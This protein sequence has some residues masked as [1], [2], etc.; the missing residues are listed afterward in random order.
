MPTLM[1]R[2]EKRANLFEQLKDINDRTQYDPQGQDLEQLNRLDAELDREDAIIA[3]IEGEQA[4]EQVYNRV[5]RTGVV[6]A[7][8][9]GQG[10]GE[11]AEYREAWSAF[12]RDGTQDMDP[13]MR[14]VLNAG[15]VN[16]PKNAAGVGT[17]SAGGYA[18]PPEFREKFVQTLKY[19]GPMLSE[20]EII[21][22]ESGANMPWPTNDDTGNVGAILAEN[23][24]V[25]EQDVTL[26]QASIDAYM[27]TSK[28]VRVSFQLMQDMPTFDSW[29]IERLGE[30]I[31]RI[32]NAHFTTGTNSSQPN[33]I[34]TGG[35]VGVT[36]TGSFAT[37]GVLGTGK[38]DNIIDLVE[39][40]D[41]AYGAST[42]LKFMG[43]QAVR[44]AVRKLQDSQG[45][46]MWEISL[47]N[48][49]PDSLLGYQFL[50]NNDMAT[51]AVSSKSLLF[52]DIRA[53]YLAR[54]VKE[55]TTL[56]LTERYADFL[57]VGFLAFERADGEVQNANAYR[58]F[59]TS[60]SA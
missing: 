27:Y 49:V 1:E 11:Q 59:Q 33:G 13:E 50:L 39:S 45:R 24:A 53:A 15:R 43:H 21:E 8:D 60:A 47:Q 14:K 18:V 4:R 48:G 30:R 26:G 51:P 6:P 29:L 56:R 20:A 31:G 25:S 41:P 57:Q 22:T 7:G 37:T 17:G 35:T 16:L 9:G 54:I 12:L 40:L 52:G 10:A 32:L 42:N 28:L 38:G 19:Y 36:G 23:T 44:K 58:V 46:Y 34:V 55:L 3:R 2:R 5:D